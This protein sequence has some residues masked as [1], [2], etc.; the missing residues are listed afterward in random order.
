MARERKA[1]MEAM[2]QQVPLTAS[3]RV[4]Y[5]AGREV[6]PTVSP[7]QGSR[8]GGHVVREAPTLHP[9]RRPSAVPPV[10]LPAGHRPQRGR[11]APA[12]G[13]RASRPPDSPP[14]R[15]RTSAFRAGSVLTSRS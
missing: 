7:G 2:A 14:A 12:G 5:V 11:H 6:T 8:P 9:Y 1:C 4:R 3:S 10:G 15:F 13:R